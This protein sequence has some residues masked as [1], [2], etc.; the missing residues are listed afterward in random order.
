MIEELSILKYIQEAYLEG[1][2]WAPETVTVNDQPVSGLSRSEFESLVEKIDSRPRWFRNFQLVI[3]ASSSYETETQVLTLQN[4]VSFE[5][6]GATEM[7]SESGEDSADWAGRISNH[8]SDGEHR[9]GV[10]LI[11]EALSISDIDELE[12]SITI[13]KS[14]IVEDFCDENSV[15]GSDADVQLW[16]SKETLEQWIKRFSVEYII[17]SQ[18]SDM[19]TPYHYFL[20]NEGVEE[21]R[22]LGFV[23]AHSLENSETDFLPVDCQENYRGEQEILSSVFEDTKFRTPPVSPLVFDNSVIREVYQTAFVFAAT[24]C[25][26][27]DYSLSGDSFEAETKTD[28]HHTRSEFDFNESSDVSLDDQQLNDL[29]DLLEQVLHD[30]GPSSLNH[31]HQAVATHCSSFTE[32]PLK[33]REIVHYCGFLQ[34]EAAKQELEQLQN[35]VEEA[36]ELTRTV[37]NSL[38]EASQS[39]TSDLQKVIITLLAAIVTNFVLILRYSDLHVLAPFSVAAI[40][41]ILIFYFPIIQTEIDE[42]QSVMK[43]RTGDFII[44]LSEIRSHVGTRV[45]DLE[46]IEDQHKVHLRTAFN[47]LQNA[48]QTTSKIYLLLV[49][50]WVIIIF[51]GLLII[52][53]NTFVSLQSS[54]SDLG[55]QT[56]TDQGQGIIK[57]SILVST[58]PAIWLL[59]KL[60]SYHHSSEGRFLSCS[61][62]PAESANDPEI[63]FPQIEAESTSMDEVDIDFFE[64]A[65]P[66]HYFEYCPPLL[67]ILLISIIAIAGAAICIN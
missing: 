9:E 28:R 17:D 19:S 32:I 62:S 67:T 63:N 30:D 3:P 31:W 29:Y 10:E 8:F 54:L 51:Y 55:L 20:E 61:M 37:A 27:S 56:S 12:L 57:I 34:E 65:T 18:F 46:K 4:G 13:N 59:Y 14:H 64:N 53:D 36:F 49:L 60:F 39:L 35:T 11:F 21:S 2:T 41:A 40:A 50:I 38:S 47:S 58:V 24:A 52:A 26:A 44:Y 15:G 45:F 43:N 6:G 42:T 16:T 25:L 23:S 5:Q 1:A 48:R 7:L 22:F 33:R 66:R